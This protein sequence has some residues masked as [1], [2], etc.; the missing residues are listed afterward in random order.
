MAG[1]FS[2]SRSIQ[3]GGPEISEAE[4]GSASFCDFVQKVVAYARI[5]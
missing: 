2:V 4:T 3:S 5:K 1:L